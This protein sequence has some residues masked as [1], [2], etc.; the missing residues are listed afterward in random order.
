M[1]KVPIRFVITGLFFSHDKKWKMKGCANTR[2]L[3]HEVDNPDNEMQF[4]SYSTVEVEDGDAKSILTYA[5]DL[6]GRYTSDIR[7]AEDCIKS[8]N[9]QG[10]VEKEDNDEEDL[11]S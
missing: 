3:C 4:S 6:I 11:E 5:R 8:L 2:I 1:K 7:E 10:I 9:E